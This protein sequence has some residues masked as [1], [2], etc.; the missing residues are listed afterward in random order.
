MKLAPQRIYP[1]LVLLLAIV[2]VL[3]VIMALWILRFA[4]GQ[5]TALHAARSVAT[6]VLAADAL[7]DSGDG[8]QRLGELGIRL[9]EETP[10][11]RPTGLLLVN[12]IE[13][14]LHGLLPQRDLRFTAAPEP[15]LWVARRE[16]GQGWIGV[17]LLSLRGSL[18][19]TAI[20]A[21]GLGLLLILAAGA[22][23][24]RSLTAPLRRL[25]AAAP[26]I[27]AGAE[28]PPL[29]ANA[30]QEL[31]DLDRA[32]AQAASDV[33]AA[34]RDRELMLAAL[35][36]DMRTPLARVR[37]QLELSQAIAPLERAGIEQD[38]EEIDALIEQFI[39]YV[40]DGRDEP[41]EDVDLAALLHQ[42]GDAEARAGFS[43]TVVAPDSC[44]LRVKP[45]ALRRA[46]GNLIAN[47]QRHGA[48]PFRMTLHHAGSRAII[49]VSDGGKGI[50]AQLLPHL[51]EPF[52]RGNPARGGAGS[53][54]GLGSVKRVASQHGGSVEF[55]NSEAGGFVARL[56][57]PL[58]A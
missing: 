35:S 19:W 42:I 5:V 27:A 12:D 8:R 37:L 46:L 55:A 53:G 50:D 6:E 16:P 10:P 25:A 36:H 2:S 52:H 14:Q 26:D 56:V 3:V 11:A 20:V 21:M 43:W 41:G 15:M 23:Y 44:L 45:L 51:G 54:L 49:E 24:A 13:R 31:H 7:A 1:R 9:A 38:I 34:A 28:P 18:L 4:S 30:A 57:L 33:R 29:A 40:R 22:W 17:P 58:G 47:A 48:A 39:G 32:L